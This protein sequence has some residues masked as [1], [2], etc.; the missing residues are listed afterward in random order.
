METSVVDIAENM[1]SRIQ[2]GHFWLWLPWGVGVG[3]GS[4]VTMSPQY[5]HWSFNL[6]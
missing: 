5:E 4:I 1:K 6:Y 3:Y 2:L